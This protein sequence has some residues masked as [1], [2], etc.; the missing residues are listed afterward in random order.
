M[1][2]FDGITQFETAFEG[3]EGKTPT[4][5]YDTTQIA[6]A[7]LTPLDRIREL[8]P[9]E[10]VHPLRATRRSGITIVTGYDYRDTDIGPYREV[11][12][13]FPVTV[14]KPSPIGAGLRRFVSRGGPIWIWQLPVTTEIARDL[15]IGIAGYPKFLAEIEVHS[16]D[17]VAVCRLREGGSEI[18]TLRVKHRSPRKVDGRMYYEPITMKGTRLLR[19]SVVAGYP[20]LARSLAGRGVTLAIG[21]HPIS[22][23]IRDLELGRA[24]MG[25]YSPDCRFILSTPL[26]GWPIAG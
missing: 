13:G 1:E 16:D 25:L 6:A 10:R 4:F 15:G 5:Y 17:G 7:F 14:G 24:V 19:S 23:K 22:E 12:I 26:E 18:L 9:D 21:E 20:H 3:H 11:L 2:F 8:L